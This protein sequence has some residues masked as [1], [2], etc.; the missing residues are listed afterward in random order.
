MASTISEAFDKENHVSADRLQLDGM[1]A[2]LGT[3][4]NV[5]RDGISI[6]RRVLACVKWAR[7]QW[8]PPAASSDAVTAP[9]PAF[10][11][12]VGRARMSIRN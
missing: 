7:V 6:T 1:R 12:N 5:M 11:G 8:K 4:S 10:T 9:P 2:D 3:T